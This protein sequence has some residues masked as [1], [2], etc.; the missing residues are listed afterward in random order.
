MTESNWSGRFSPRMLYDWQGLKITKDQAKKLA[1]K[2]NQDDTAASGFA[3]FKDWLRYIEKT[4]ENGIDGL[5]RET[6]NEEPGD[7]VEESLTEAVQN[8]SIDT[9]QETITVATKQDTSGA[10]MIVPPT[11]EVV[12]EIP[13]EAEVDEAPAEDLPV[14]D[15]GLEDIGDLDLGDNE[16]DVDV[17]E[18]DEDEFS[19][20]GESYLRKTYNNVES[21]KTTGFTFK[22]NTIFVEGLITFKGGKTS[23]TSFVF[24]GKHSHEGKFYF[25]GYNKHL[26]ESN[27]A[28][29]LVARPEGKK[30]MV[31][32]FNWNYDAKDKNGNIQKLSG[33]RKRLNK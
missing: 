27:N 16:V 33:T 31:E 21:F 11:D 2:L 14:E 12:D 19:G 24:E 10:E 9:D 6:F 22:G 25:E 1:A 30:L 29:G 8:V 17:D 18:F 13:T 20:M 3:S 4:Y 15:T 7:K 28:F 23:K 32:S 26:T 5:Y